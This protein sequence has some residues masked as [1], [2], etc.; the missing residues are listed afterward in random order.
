[1]CIYKTI[2]NYG[3]NRSL[4]PK[5][6]FPA[7]AWK[8]DTKLPIMKN[9]ILMRVSIINVN[10]A[11]FKQLRNE[12]YDNPLSIANKIMSIVKMRGKLHNPV[13]GTGGTL[14]GIIDEIGTAH[15][16]YG[17]LHSGT[18]ISTL[19]S[20]KFTPLVIN[21]IRSINMKT[22][23]LEVDE[24]TGVSAGHLGKLKEVIKK[25]IRDGLKVK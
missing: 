17:K 14:Y 4:E 2:T 8:L 7:T 21:S 10:V 1:M 19:I 18:S 9:E 22:G 24:N 3:E 23:Q 16:A 20:T 12:T 5:G 6:A 15:P 11:S 25:M 13:T